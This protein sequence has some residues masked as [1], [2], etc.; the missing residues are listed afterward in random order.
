MYVYD[1]SRKDENNIHFSFMMVWCFKIAQ[2][3]EIR[4]HNK[5]T[6]RQTDKQTQGLH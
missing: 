6:D 1:V 5:Q 3:H 2:H 4:Q